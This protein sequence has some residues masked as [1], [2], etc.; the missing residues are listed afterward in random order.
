MGILYYNYEFRPPQK[1]TLV[2]VVVEAPIVLPNCLGL[3][4]VEVRV[5]GL[6]CFRLHRVWG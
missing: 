5:S 1:K 4:V 6:R 3:S 2:L